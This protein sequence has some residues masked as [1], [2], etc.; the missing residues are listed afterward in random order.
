MNNRDIY[1][2]DPATRKLVNEGVASVNDEKTSQALAVLRYELETF[3]CDGQY[4]KGMAHILETYLKNIDQA[5]Q[6]AVWVS[7]F[8]GSGKSHLV[9]ML[10]ALWV[11]T[12]FEDG[13][14]ARGIANLPTAIRDNF[15]E[16]DTQ[17]KRHGG[18]HAASGTLGAG[19]SG[20]VRLALLRIIFKSA[21]L[22]EQYPVA[23]FVM[24]LK[25]EGIETQVRAHVEQS[26]FDW[27]EELDNFYVAEGLH[28][29]LVQAK[30]KLFSSP[31]SCVETLNNLYPYVQDVSSDDMLKAIRQALTKDGKFPLTL[32]VLDEVQQY[33]GEDSQ[34]SIDVQEAVEA[35]SK[36]IGGKFL[37]IGT[38]QTAVTGTSNLKKLEGRF[39]IR[40]ELSDADVDAVIRQVIL[41]KKPE[42]RAPIEQIMQ[43]NLGE[44]SRHLAGTT[45]GHQQDDIAFFPQDYPILPVRR[46]FWENTLRVLDQTGTD[47]QLRNQLSMIHKVIQT[48]LGES[49]GNVVP[50]DYLYFDSADKLLQSRILPRKVHE[51][52]MSWSK[53][54]DDERLMGRACG[55]V[56]LINKLASSNNEIGIR[57]TIDT[58]ADLLVENLSRGSG[59]LRGKLPGLLDKCELLMK[60]GDEYRIQTEESAAWSDEFLSQ[61]SALSNEAHRI[62]AERDDRI[63]KKFGEMVRKLSLAQGSSKVTRDIYPVFDA[64]LPAD[65]EQRI[66]LW[67]R[68]GWSIDENSVRA[69]SRQ[70][71]NQSPTVFVFIPKRSAD[72][73]RHHLINYKAASAT[74]D[75]RGVPNTPEGTEARAA[76][77]TTKQAAEGKIG[78]LLIETFSGARVFQGGGNEILGND[79]QEMVLEASGN[80][81]QRLYPQFHIA[82][83]V[84]WSKVYEKAQ[85][86]A[87]DALKAVGFEAEPAKNPVCKAILGFIAGGKKG[88]DIRTQFES[89][90]CGWSRDAVDG[91]L[92]VLLVA[93]LIRAQ[94]ERGQTLDPKE[95]ERKTIGKVMFKVESATVT[96]AQR[97]LIRKLLQKV[98][99]SAKQGEELV[100][101]PQLLEKMVEL[102]DQA[103]GEAPKPARPD[104][105]F[106]DEIR[107]TAGNEQLLALY[108][109]RD[110][111]GGSIDSWTDLAER[112]VKRWP[113]WLTLNRLLDHAIKEEPQTENTISVHL[114]ESVVPDIEII[115]A[116][117]KTIEQQRQLLEEPDQVGP[118]IANLTQ[119]LRDELN[120]LDS[121]YATRHA[122]GMARLADDT[123]WQ[124]LEPEQRYQLISAQFLHES[125]RPAVA[126]Q[127][128]R[129]V[130]TTLDNCT[131][132]M[133]ADR[134]AAM[135]ARFDNVASGAAELCEPQA[136][137]IQVPRRTLKTD[138][139]IDTWVIEVQQQLKAAL[140]AGP[141]V[142]R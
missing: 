78:E 15:K 19:A 40:V 88:T 134:V 115:Y 97:I 81:Q 87:P 117:V 72:D 3:V 47:S 9:K 114:C 103:G 53:G 142:I 18:L 69:D 116:Q 8:Y 52:T 59:A 98:G 140:Q 16:L 14:T 2:K 28:D 66:Y 131:L 42:A 51:K 17:A 130:L 33:I 101:I 90:P 13:S 83:H 39:T 57:A 132:S 38:G 27:I 54:T 64:Q 24:W 65:A 73:L 129:D 70:A 55:L 22:P 41:A 110:E 12:V 138:E 128:T 21:G 92:Q 58:L 71:G 86:G 11:D 123:N 7:G 1:Q 125:A 118:L 56:F 124:Q 67:V 119:L 96:T 106:L 137:F 34:R 23:R 49:L 135:P 60:V 99:L 37:F 121:E 136:Q 82:D 94:G 68:D 120:K 74:L 36:N 61:R 108:N 5:Q 43:T 26:G 20:S 44:I 85:K 4:E 31:L 46:R 80:A 141:V 102:A 105:T 133:F 35:C 45:I 111:L 79:L 50:A 100:H 112:I 76:M 32:V 77:E 63:R 107:L 62:E 93:G 89:S 84:G 122:K 95:L 6:P 10:R 113:N 104:T 75:K 29:A 25:H 30:P 139:E 127:S 126:V 109:R 48:N 91:G